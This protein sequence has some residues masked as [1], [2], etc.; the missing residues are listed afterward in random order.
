MEMLAKEALGQSVVISVW[1][2][3]VFPRN[4]KRKMVHPLAP[5]RLSTALHLTRFPQQA[6]FLQT[7]I[8][9]SAVG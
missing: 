3:N 9:H 1:A 6:G 7:P 2:E 4:Y 5:G 8:I